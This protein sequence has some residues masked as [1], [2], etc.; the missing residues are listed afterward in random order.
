M[1]EQLAAIELLPEQSPPD[2]ELE[3]IV[4]KTDKS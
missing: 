4:K 2:K 3:E 1:L